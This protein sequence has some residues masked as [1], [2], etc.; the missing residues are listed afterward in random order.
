MNVSD[1]YSSN[2]EAEIDF[3]MESL[4]HKTTTYRLQILMKQ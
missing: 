4:S 2:Y 1:K 3:D